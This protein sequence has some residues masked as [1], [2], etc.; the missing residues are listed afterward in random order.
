MVRDAV[1]DSST[2]CL[3]CWHFC[4]SP[5]LEDEFHIARVCPEYQHARQHL[6]Q[7]LPHGSTFSTLSDLMHVVSGSDASVMAK[8]CSFFGRSRQIRRKLRLQLERYNA[9]VESQ[10]CAV[11][12]A[13]WR[14]KQKYSC[15]HGVLFHSMPVGG[16]KCMA[17][18]STEADWAQAVYMPGLNPEL[19]IITAISFDRSS[20]V[21][22]ATLQAQA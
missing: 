15:R 3:P 21:R 12:R 7:N 1:G 6:L 19:K 5:V 20:Y 10:S 13:A 8:A 11:R 16:C 14:F 4:R 17:S 2:V 9:Q 18:S 22:L